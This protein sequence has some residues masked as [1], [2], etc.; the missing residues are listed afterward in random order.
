MTGQH[1]FCAFGAIS[2]YQA[3]SINK[4]Y[5]SFEHGNRGI[6]KKIRR[7]EIQLLCVGKSLNPDPHRGKILNQ[8]PD[9]LSDAHLLEMREE[10]VDLLP[11][12][13]PQGGR[14]PR[15]F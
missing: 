8:N 11:G 12:D 3:T 4:Y 13:S 2:Y 10:G 14:L 1:F 9:R 6:S 7:V 5:L 15:L